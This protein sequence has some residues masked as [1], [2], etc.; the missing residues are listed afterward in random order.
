[1]LYEEKRDN[2]V[3]FYNVTYDK[4]KLKEILKKLEKYSYTVRIEGKIAGNITKWP[5]TK[6][7]L[8]KRVIEF[9]NA[10]KNQ[11]DLALYPETIKHCKEDGN[12]YVTYEYSYT[13]MP[14]LYHYIN[15]MINNKDIMDYV[16]LFGYVT[17]ELNMLYAITHKEQ[18]IIEGVINYINSKELINHNLENNE[19]INNDKYDYK[20]LNEL[21]KEALECFELK[22][23]A[24]KEYLDNQEIIPVSSLQRKNTLYNN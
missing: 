3:Y 6:N 7:I 15:I 21:Y 12:D 9:F 16:N 24:K 19:E 5:V 4:E 22:L 18:L 11:L 13:K 2:I 8:E 14:D 10:T 17:G 20:G 1:M 23:I